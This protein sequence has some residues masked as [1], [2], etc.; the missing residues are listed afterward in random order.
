MA[1]GILNEAGNG[2]AGAQRSAK[3]KV[4]SQLSTESCNLIS[5]LR[6][7]P[8]TRSAQHPTTPVLPRKLAATPAP[9][10]P[11]GWLLPVGRTQVCRQALE[12][13]FKSNTQITGGL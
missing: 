5:L 8:S 7:A 9:Q 10:L 4:S 11:P 2:S 13:Y 6:R 3:D 1:G 12:G